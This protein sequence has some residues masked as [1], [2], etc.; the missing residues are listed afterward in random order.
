MWGLLR[1]A[2]EDWPAN[3]SHGPASVEEVVGA[4]L[5]WAAMGLTGWLTLTFLTVALG[6]APGARGA[7]F[8]Q[9]G[10]SLTP[11]FARRALS[12]ALGASVGTVALPAPVAI[13]TSVATSLPDGHVGETGTTAPTPGYRATTA[14]P[15]VPP[16]G[17]LPDRPARVTQSDATAL[18]GPALR[19][20]AAVSDTVTVRRGDTLWSIAAGHLGSG[21][22]DAE[23]AAEW[24]RW[25][26][27]NRAVIGDDP[28]IIL[29]GQQLLAPLAEVAR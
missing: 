25:F 16:P 7:A 23:V 8:R 22:T 18:L 17:W 2:L 11:H 20:N 28:D 29:P 24:P 3:P 13:A 21:A 12:L 26:E 10:R 14:E 4:G 5:A 1:L 15:A 19:P 27:A 9:L 6:A